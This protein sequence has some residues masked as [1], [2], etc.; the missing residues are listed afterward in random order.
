LSCLP[1]GYSQEL[2]ASGID[3]E[4]AKFTAYPRWYALFV[5]SRHEKRLAGHCSERQIESFLPLYQVKHR[6]KNRCT[7]TLD[8]PLF[9]NY[10]FVRIERQQRIQ[11]LNL[12][13]VLSIVSSGREML[14]ISDEYMT[15]LRNGLLAH[16]IAPHP[17][18]EVGDRV[19]ITTGPMAGMEGILS[20]QKNE[21]RVVLLLEMIGRSVVV[22]VGAEE[23]CYVGPHGAH[24]RMERHGFSQPLNAGTG[25]G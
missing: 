20:R 7:A 2:C 25:W 4:P 5:M 8:L 24:T 18:V 6:W 21:L 16:R 1:L 14:P 17:N 22:E 23:I 11:I 19:C 3:L 12:P 13:G 15:S 10:V 9:P